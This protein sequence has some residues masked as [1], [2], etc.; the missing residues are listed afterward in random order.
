MGPAFAGPLKAARAV[1][2]T[3]SARAACGSA[4]VAVLHCSAIMI[5]S[6]ASAVL[7]V[8]ISVLASCGL[9]SNQEAP[10]GTQSVA[11]PLIADEGFWMG[12][13]H[14]INNVILAEREGIRLV[15]N[16][17]LALSSPKRTSRERST[18]T[19]SSIPFAPRS[20]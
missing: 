6:R 3:V 15:A 20:A 11:S 17:N 13:Y 2:L 14:P 4:L 5:R 16:G 1:K 10:T 12:V 8:A 7:G 18:P 9:G 19:T